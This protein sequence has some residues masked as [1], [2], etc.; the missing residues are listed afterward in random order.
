[1]LNK[2]SAL[3]WLPLI[4]NLDVNIPQTSI[5]LLNEADKILIPLDDFSSIN[6]VPKS[7]PV[8]IKTDL[9]SRKHDWR[10]TCYVENVFKYFNNI[11]NLVLD[12]IKCGE[13]VNAILV[14]E[15]IQSKPLDHMFNNMP[16]PIEM[17]Y[18]IKD[19]EI[20]YKYFYWKGMVD[21]ENLIYT[22]PDEQASEIAEHM[23]GEWSVDFLMDKHG[24]WWLIDMALAENSERL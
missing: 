7:Y 18:F 6:V 22:P 5:I 1:M 14:R 9:I 17:R 8:F 10:N 19:N 21:E 23:D 24:V 4:H 13:E 2:D 20:E 15:F 16:I 3:Y 12:S 11:K